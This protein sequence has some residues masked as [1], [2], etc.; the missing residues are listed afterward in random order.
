MSLSLIQG[1]FTQR[2]DAADNQQS[3]LFQRNQTPPLDREMHLVDVPLLLAVELALYPWH[4]L[5]ELVLS[6]V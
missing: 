6:V 4:N 2:S 3:H 1:F 5:V